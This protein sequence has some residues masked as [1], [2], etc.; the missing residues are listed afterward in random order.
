MDAEKNAI[1]VRDITIPK[2]KCPEFQWGNEQEAFGK[3]TK[4][5]PD[6]ELVSVI[7]IS[8]FVRRVYMKPLSKS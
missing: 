3:L 4:N 6:W 7:A 2:N 1:L 8:K 5:F